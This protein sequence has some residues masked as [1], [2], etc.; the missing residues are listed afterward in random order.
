M[1]NDLAG[2]SV[3]R[4]KGLCKLTTLNPS[5]PDPVFLTYAEPVAY[6]VSMVRTYMYLNPVCPDQ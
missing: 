6:V 5:V 3:G 1:H 2:Y 4:F